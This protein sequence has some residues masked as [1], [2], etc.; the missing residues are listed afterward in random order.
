VSHDHYLFFKK[1]Y[2]AF[3]YDDKKK[4]T[5]Q[6]CLFESQEDGKERPDATNA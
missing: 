1:L 3:E 5:F 2:L 4:A 6:M